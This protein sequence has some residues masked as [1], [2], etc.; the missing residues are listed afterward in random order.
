MAS[1]PGLV[2]LSCLLVA[3]SNEKDR[4]VETYLALPISSLGHWVC[5][6][7]AQVLRMRF[8]FQVLF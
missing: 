2:T 3:G 8:K 1:S 4:R 5:A 6:L 7:T